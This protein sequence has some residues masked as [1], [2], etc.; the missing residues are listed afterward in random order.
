MQ[1]N[2]ASGDAWDCYQSK[3][4]EEGKDKPCASTKASRT[5]CTA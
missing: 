5:F 3:D 4:W 2:P 1:V